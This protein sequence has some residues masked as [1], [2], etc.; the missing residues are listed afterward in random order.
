MESTRNLN[1]EYY[2]AHHY[3]QCWIMEHSVPRGPG[4]QYSIHRDPSDVWKDQTP[5]KK[6]Y[7][8]KLEPQLSWVR[9]EF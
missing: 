9:G 7:I 3:E 2:K 5:M 4:V 8:V 6:W 1:R